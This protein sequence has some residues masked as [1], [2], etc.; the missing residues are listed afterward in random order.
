M[1]GVH[2]QLAESI[3]LVDYFLL[4]L[5]ELFHRLYQLLIIPKQY[6]H[7][8]LLLRQLRPHLIVLPHDVYDLAQHQ[9]REGALQLPGIEVLDRV[10]V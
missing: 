5:P 2:I 3:V 1:E 10:D 8:L 9:A 7:L 4:V 6:F